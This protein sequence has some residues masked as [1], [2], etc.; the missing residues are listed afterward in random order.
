MSFEDIRN[1]ALAEWRALQNSG[2]PLIL[3]GTATCGQAAGAGDVIDTV[4]TVLSRS[5]IEA[6]VMQVGCIGLCYA[7]PIVDIIKPGRPRITYGGITP[8]II[9]QLIEDYLVN[10]NPRPELALGTIGEEGVDNIPRL[11]ELPVFK[12]QVRLALR[13]CGHIDPCEIKQ[14]IA[15]DG[16]SGLLKALEKSQHIYETSDSM[17]L[18]VLAKIL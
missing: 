4:E 11:F 6:T 7:E 3:V 12:P 16:Y 13:N 15:N 2:K 10:D 5:S 9:T 1:Q 14:Y 17:I 18:P 8:E